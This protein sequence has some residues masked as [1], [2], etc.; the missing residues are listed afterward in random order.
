MHRL[1][2]DYPEN[3]ARGCLSTTL[4]RLRRVLEPENVTQGTYLLT[5]YA[6]EVGFNWDSD[7]WLDVAVFENRATATLGRSLES[8]ARV[9]VEALENTVA[10]YTGDLLEGFYEDWAIREQERLS[11][12]YLDCLE[13]LMRYY[14][15]RHKYE[16]SMAYGQRLLAQEPIRE[17]IHREMMRLYVENGQR[18]LAVRQYETCRDILAKELNL[19]PMLETQALYAEILQGEVSTTR[20][21]N[22]DGLWQA[23]AQLS[24]ATRNFENA[25]HQLKLVGQKLD[26]TQQQLQTALRL[27]EHLTNR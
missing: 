17:S 19:A 18:A 6:D 11:C 21:A 20:P 5:T 4:W 15:H 7:F 2:G 12:L 24:E 9:D 16:K 26:Q 23:L 22:Q 25:K 8:V 27:V 3:K 1:W 10:L 13:Y 14:R